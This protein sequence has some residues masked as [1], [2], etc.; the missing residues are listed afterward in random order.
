MKLSVSAWSVH[1]NLFGKKTSLNE[2]IDICLD[3]GVKAVE[4]LDCFWEHEKQPYEVKKYIDSKNMVVSAYSIA[5]DFVQEEEERL[6]QI[7]AVKRGI[8]MAVLLETPLLR[9]FS[10]DIKEGISFDE[11]KQWIIDSFK[12]CA[13]YA[14]DKGI[15]MVLENH[16]YFAGRSEQVKEI[17]QAVDSNALKANTDTGNFLLVGEN[18]LDA[19]RNLKDYI[20]FVHF[21]DFRKVSEEG[22]YM[23]MDGTWFEG[24]VI[25]HGDAPLAEIVKYLKESGYNGY[26][27]IEYEG[28]GDPIQGT[29]DSIKIAL[30][31][32]NA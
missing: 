19:V 10:G 9:V 5:N 25:G 27:S 28:S 18:P 11:G 14:E 13:S 2:F 17:L 4:L 29:V 24:E 15:T 6:A 16:G 12:A 21:K 26:F 7:D 20:G 8:D 22:T 32:L 1:P 31:I 30:D 23:A 3:N